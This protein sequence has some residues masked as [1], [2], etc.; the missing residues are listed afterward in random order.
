MQSNRH[1]N[2]KVLNA[3]LTKKRL[4]FM[5]FAAGVSV[6]NLY[7]N[8]PLLNQIRLDFHGTFDEVATIP[9]LTQ[10][11]YALGMFFLVPLGDMLDRKK[12]ILLFTLLGAIC[13]G[14]IAVANHL[15]LVMAM[16]LLV[17][18]FT[19]TPQLLVP[20]AAHLA[21]PE[22]RGKVVGTMVSGILLGILLARTVSGF[23]G[24]IYGWRTMFLVASVILAALTLLLWK[25]LPDSSQSARSYK[26]SYLGLLKSVLQIVKE[27]PVLREVCLIGAMYFGAFSAFWV[28]LVFL[29]AKSYFHL[30][31]PA[32]QAVGLFALLG[33]IA[34][35]SGPL[36]GT[37]MDRTDA[38]KV[39]G[40]MLLLTLLSFGIFGFSDHSLWGLGVGIILMDIGVQC[41][42][43]ANQS[44]IFKLLPH[45]QSRLQTAY[46]FSYFVGG[47][48]GSKLGS[49][50]WSYYGWLGVCVVAVAMLLVAF[51]P[52]CRVDKNDQAVAQVKF[53]ATK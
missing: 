44:R 21:L 22:K 32:E 51:L 42:H 3:V 6:A 34:A 29:L 11:G 7:Y 26:G 19:M 9:T 38:R 41:G 25:I 39:T 17:G 31:M 15:N 43:V 27:Q 35:F 4:I 5:S 24:S 14:I 10:I 50:A 40:F 36:F 52:F 1:R 49:I 46:M 16:S 2:V 47:A 23:V 53:N 13:C 12:L 48:I 20:L 28:N 33:A 8:Q 45:S 30:S 37:W 18:L